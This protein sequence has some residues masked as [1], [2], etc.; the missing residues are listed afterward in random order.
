MTRRH[1]A[2]IPLTHDH[3]HALHNVRLLQKAA[4]AEGAE[5][6]EAA[7]AFV[8]FFRDHSVQHFREEEEELFPM[9]VGLP[10]A[11]L[12]GVARILLEHV[13]IHAS[14][15]DLQRQAADGDVDPQTMRSLGD[16]L[17]AHIRFEE[18]EL[19]PVIE[20]MVPDE[21]R[22]LTLAEREREPGG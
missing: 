8:D 21:L 17:K 12:D 1:D 16:L 13:Q 11:P 9:V 14:V 18:N 20:A 5:R 15:K 10:D 22:G 19:F 3:H 6:V 7:L 4:D 2:L